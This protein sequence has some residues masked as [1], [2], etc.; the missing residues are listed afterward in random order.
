MSKCP[1]GQSGESQVEYI[2]LCEELYNI[3]RTVLASDPIKHQSVGGA[4]ILHINHVILNLH[5]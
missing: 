3:F 1:G 4:A 2:T 5:L